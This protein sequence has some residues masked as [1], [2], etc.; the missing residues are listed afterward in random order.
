MN[1]IQIHKYVKIVSIKKKYVSKSIYLKHDI[2]QKKKHEYDTN[3]WIS[4]SN[5]IQ[6]SIVKSFILLLKIGYNLYN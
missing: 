4:K 3:T 1:M 5:T 6:S 2:I